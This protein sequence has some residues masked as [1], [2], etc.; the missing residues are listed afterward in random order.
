METHNRKLD[1]KGS[2]TQTNCW[3][4]LTELQDFHPEREVEKMREKERQC[5][6]AEFMIILLKHM[7]VML[8]L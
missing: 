2:P 8:K 4:D 1:Q 5:D 6:P 3:T 7:P